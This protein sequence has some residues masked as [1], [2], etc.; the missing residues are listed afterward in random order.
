M[1]PLKSLPGCQHVL[2]QAFQLKPVLVL[3]TL[4]VGCAGRVVRRKSEYRIG[5]VSSSCQ[6][7]QDLSLG[8]QWR[9]LLS[10][11]MECAQSQ[12]WTAASANPPLG[13]RSLTASAV[14][15][16]SSSRSWVLKRG[17]N[18]ILYFVQAKTTALIS[19][20]FC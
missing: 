20:S 19:W 9:C 17:Q 2:L 7:S 3:S 5:P 12:S 15:C 13:I 14:S 10:C 11:L 16:C 4:W 6:G 1:R 18:L 8:S